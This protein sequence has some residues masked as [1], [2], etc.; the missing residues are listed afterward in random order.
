MTSKH[1]CPH[2]GKYDWYRV[3]NGISKSGKTFYE[4]DQCSSCSY[5][6]RVGSRVH[7]RGER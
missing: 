6:E 3:M 2:C 4:Y 7:S 1:K 5:V